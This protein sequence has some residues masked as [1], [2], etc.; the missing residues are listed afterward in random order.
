MN[1]E[2]HYFIEEGSIQKQEKMSS[3]PSILIYA[4]RTYFDE[5]EI[6]AHNFTTFLLKS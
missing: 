3:I 5:D 6:K 4:L 1:I 2:S